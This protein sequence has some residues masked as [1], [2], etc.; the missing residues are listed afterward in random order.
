[1]DDARRVLPVQAALLVVAN[2]EVDTALPFG[3]I[4]LPLLPPLLLMKLLALPL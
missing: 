4:S 1:M 2:V 3:L